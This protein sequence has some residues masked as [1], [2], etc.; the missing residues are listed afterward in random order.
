MSPWVVDGGSGE[1]REG[2]MFEV[3]D[4]CVTEQERGCSA[5]LGISLS[6]LPLRDKDGLLFHGR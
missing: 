6:E 3:V 4:Y 2:A 5:L 1:V